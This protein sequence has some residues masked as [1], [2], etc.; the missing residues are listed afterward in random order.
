MVSLN[1]ILGRLLKSE[2]SGEQIS[3]GGETVLWGGGC[4][5]TGRWTA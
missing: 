4:T 1:L 3:S 5:G 2:V